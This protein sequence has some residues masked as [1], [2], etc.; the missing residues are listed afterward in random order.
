MHR[1]FFLKEGVW[2][3]EDMEKLG[4]PEHLADLR[5][6]LIRS[7]LAVIIC[8]SAAYYYIE[9]I[10]DWFFKPLFDVLP[11]GSSLIFIS[12]QEAFFFT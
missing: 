1:F 6:C 2:T 3:M 4:L 11:K 5:T 9:P 12:Y 10:G 7:L 8:F